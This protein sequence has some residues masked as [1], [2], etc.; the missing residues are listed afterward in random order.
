MATRIPSET[1]PSTLPEVTVSGVEPVYVDNMIRERVLIHG[2]I[3]QMEPIAEISC[4]HIPPDQIGCIKPGPVKKFMDARGAHD[5][6]NRRRKVKLQRKRAREYAR[7]EREG[8]ALGSYEGET[9][10]PAALAGRASLA[11]AAKLHRQSAGVKQD[12]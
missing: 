2:R 1:T 4:L 5:Q 7:A 10:P 12:C 3:R 8:F 6:S 11:D 9:P